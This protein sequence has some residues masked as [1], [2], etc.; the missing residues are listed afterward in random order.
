MASNGAAKDQAFGAFL[1]NRYKNFPN[2]VWLNGNDFQNWGDPAADANALALARGIASTDPA[3]IQTIELNFTNSSSLDDQRWA[4]T[5]S[6]NAA[7]TYFATYDEVL[8]AY[9]QSPTTPTFMVEANYE[10]ENLQLPPDTD[11]ETLRRQEWWTMTSGATGQLYGNHTTWTFPSNWKSNLDT[12]GVAQLGVMRSFFLSEPWQQLVPDSTFVTSGQGS[13][14]SGPVDVL[15]TDYATAAVT[16]DGAH[17]VVYVPT[18]R[19]LTVNLS[20]L[21]ANVTARWIDPT[22]GA[23]QPAVAPYTTPGRH[24]DGATDWALAFD[25]S[26]TTV[27]D[28]STTTTT[29]VPPTTTTTVPPTT[30]TTTVPPTTTTVPPTTTT[31]TVPPTTTTVPPTT[32]TTTVPPTTTTV[33]PTT[34]TTTVPPTTTTVPPTTTTTTVPPTTTTVPPTTTTTTVPPTTTTTVPPTTTTT[35]VPPTTTTTVPPT[36]TTTTVPPTTTTTTPPGVV[37][38]V[39]TPPPAPAPAPANLGYWLT[40]SDGGVFTFG[41]AGFYGST[42]NTPLNRPIVTMAPTPTG[43]GY[44]LVASDGGVFTFGDATFYGSTG[45]TPL[46]RPIVTMAATPTGHGYWLVASDG[47]VFTFGDAAFYGSTGGIPLNRPIVDHGTDPHRPRLL[48]RRIRRRR[49]HLRRRHLL[50]LDR[51]HPPQPPDRRHGTDR[52]PA[53]ATGSSHP[54]AASS[55]SATPPSTDPPATSASTAQSSPWPPPPPAT[56]TGSSHPTAAS[57]PSATPPSSDPPATCI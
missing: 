33:P 22:T 25:A 1:G 6:L 17:A 55:P 41:G 12:T 18:A 2:I 30:T 46:N 26:A 19:T 4:T 28:N 34:T 7:Y 21:Q 44:W 37:P 47:G 10:N 40:A 56:A 38:A 57:S 9:N 53:T 29:T 39:T 52:R 23:S 24:A 27:P 36:T 15:Q 43:H 20:R 50:R 14:N 5:V 16:P 3:H 32:T 48:A 31:T 54:T 51:Q 8:H 35:T 13:Y 45:N 42:G 49:L 11:A